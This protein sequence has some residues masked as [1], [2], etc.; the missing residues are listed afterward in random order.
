[1]LGGAL[2]T[3]AAVAGLGSQA[4]ARGSGGY[5]AVRAD[6][7][8]P[9]GALGLGPGG[10]LLP[11]DTLPYPHLPAGTDTLPQVEHVV[12]LMMENHS[13][14]DHFGALGRGDGLSVAHDGTPLN[15]NP[16]P[17]GGYIL[18]FPM[19]NTATPV[20]GH[21]SQS[22]DAS[23]L[24]WDNG[25][26]AGFAQTCGPASMGHFTGDQLPFYYSLASQFPIG[27]RYFASVM[28]Q[29]YPNRRF[30]IAATALGN[31]ATNATGISA[32]DAP[33]GTIFDRL[34]S[35]GITWKD[36]FPD[37][38]TAALFLPEF[39]NNRTDGRMAP[40]NQFLADAAA[41]Q[42]P[43]FSLVDPYTNFSE[44]DGD[45]SIGEAYAAR[46]IDAVLTSP[47]WPSTAMFLVYDEHGGWYDH[48]PPQPA[49]RPDDV[50]PEITVPPDQPG[51]YD[52]TGFRVPCVVISPFA[53][54]KFVS[55]IVH[56]HTSL[57]KFVETK[58]NLPAMTYRDA[59]ATNMFEFF[60]FEGRPHFIE[61]PPLQAP[62][63]PFVGP[64]P[65]GSGSPGFHPIATGVP[66][67]SLPPAAFRVSSP[68]V[69]EPRGRDF[70]DLESI[71]DGRS[72]LPSVNKS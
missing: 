25:T 15:F 26:N 23:H 39:L 11:P 14:D 13:F 42:L 60:K 37:L 71:A 16:A 29:T 6:G 32:T 20:G 28:G 66:A 61:P 33:N 9:S 67:N 1:M 4:A 47:N 64:L 2:A 38:P 5:R 7:S 30:L 59:N 22:W 8:A 21:I 35:H 43:Q 10:L 36:Y 40:I 54:R 41:G 58:W 65:A 44:E 45:I 55:H 62:L 63:N 48:V 46:V 51:G 27:D 19:P 69:G 68:P 12:I 57:L 17:G 24:C 50:P 3:G 34:D 31:V 56:E 18:S 70:G 52:F 72:R 53:R 49:V